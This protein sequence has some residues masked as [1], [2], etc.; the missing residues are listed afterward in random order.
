MDAYKALST[1]LNLRK[2]RDMFCIVAGHICR[3]TNISRPVEC[4]MLVINKH[5]LF[6]LNQRAN[7]TLLVLQPD[8]Y[9]IL[10]IIL[11]SIYKYATVNLYI[12]GCFAWFI[13]CTGP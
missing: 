10:L 9:A 7:R 8:I 6:L 11:S 13:Q 1:M 4:Q 12:V 5:Q 2:H 3:F